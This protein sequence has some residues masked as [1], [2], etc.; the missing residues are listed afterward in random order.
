[1]RKLAKAVPHAAR[2][3]PLASGRILIAARIWWYSWQRFF[4]PKAATGDTPGAPHWSV[5]PGR[6][7]RIAASYATKR[8]LQLTFSRAA[9]RP[10]EACRLSLKSFRQNEA[11]I[12]RADIAVIETV[13]LCPRYARKGARGARL[14]RPEKAYNGR[15]AD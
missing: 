6:H 7:H 13:N 3:A 5:L 2:F 10:P 8:V 1:M 15:I 11:A 12:T 4:T 9:K 14:S